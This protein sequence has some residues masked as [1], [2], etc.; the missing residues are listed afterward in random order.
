MSFVVKGTGQ[1]GPVTREHA[2]AKAAVE[3]AIG[4]MG[5]GFRDVQLV[6]PDG[7]VYRPQEFPRLLSERGKFDA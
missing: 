6:D 7:K 2:R 4:L 1:H 3:D 5:Q